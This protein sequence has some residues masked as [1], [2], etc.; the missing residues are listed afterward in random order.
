MKKNKRSEKYFELQKKM[1]TL[2]VHPVTMWEIMED[3]FDLTCYSY[4]DNNMIIVQNFYDGGG[5]FPYIMIK[6][7]T[8]DKVALSIGESL[9]K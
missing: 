5:I 7:G 4:G 1:E 3:R 9:L 2:L 6:G 8:W